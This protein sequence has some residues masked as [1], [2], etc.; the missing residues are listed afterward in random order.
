MADKIN[1]TRYQDTSRL[2]PPLNMGTTKDSFQMAEKTP[3]DSDKLKTN[4]KGTLT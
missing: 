2:L 4:V 3:A 1:I